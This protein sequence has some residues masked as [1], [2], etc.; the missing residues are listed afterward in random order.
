[1]NMTDIQVGFLLETFK[2]DGATPEVAKRA[3]RSLGI[4]ESVA[5]KS[6]SVYRKSYEEA[7]V[8]AGVGIDPKGPAES[9]RSRQLRESA[10]RLI[11]RAH[12][13]EAKG[14]PNASLQELEA[15]A[16]ISFGR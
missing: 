7:L 8:A 9:A 15:L 13:A 2:R 14:L 16:A 5:V 3:A 4:S 11:T 12:A 1:M 10:E 6:A